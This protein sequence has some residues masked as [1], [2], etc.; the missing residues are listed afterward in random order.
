MTDD[1]TET[2]PIVQTTHGKVKGILLKSL[3]DEQFYAFDGIPYAVPPL[4]TLRF[5][6]PHDLKPWHGIRDC[7]K[8]SNKCLQVS[9][10]TKMVEGSEDCL[11]LNI[12]AK[13]LLGE[14]MPIMVYI[15]G[16]AFKGGDSS[17]RAWGPDYFMKE[18]VL[19]ISIGHRLGPLGFLSFEDPSLEIPGNAG[20]KDIILALQWIR[21]N[22]AKF[23]GD[24]DRITIFGHSSGSMAV[25]LLLASPQTEGL[26][27]K[28]ILMAGYSMEL[29]SLPHL[30]F[31]LAKHLGYEGE[32]ID[33]PV[34]EFLLKADPHLLVSADFF[35]PAEK[36][37][38]H[39][40]AFKPSIERYATPKAVL[41]AEP[42]DLQRTAWS[43]RIPII[44]G[45]N[46][47]EG[48]S[49]MNFLKLNPTWLRD[50]QQNPE[51]ALPWTLRNHCDPG[52]RRQ[53]GQ[54]LINH[55][56]QAHG[57][58]LTSNHTDAL[59]DL[60][61]HSMVHS[62]DRLIQSRLV[63]GQASTYLYRFDFDSPDFNFYRIRFMGKEQRGV[64]HVDELGYIFVIPATFKLDN[65]RPELTAICRMVAMF[66]EFAATSDPNALLTKPL[67]EWKPVTR[68]GKRMV[69][70]ISEELKFIP[71]PEMLKLKFFDRLFE[72]AGVPFCF[73][74]DFA[75]LR[76]TH[77]TDNTRCNRTMSEGQETCELTLPLGQI[78]GVKRRS[79][80]DDT[81]FSFEKIPFAKPPVGELRFKAPVPAD[82]WS[83]VLDCTHFAEKPTQRNLM[84]RD[85]EGIEDC[86]YLNVYSKQLKSDKPLPVMVYIYGGAF[87]IGEATRELYGPDYFMAKDVVLVTL[88][89]RVDCL[90]FLSLKDPSLK[91]PGNAGLKD[92][93][94]ALKW[95]KQNI[96]NFNGDDKNITVFG[97][98]AGGCSTHFM[99]CSEQARGLFHKA[100]PMSGTVHNYWSDSPREDFAFRL[101]QQ[102]G[103]TGE[104]NDA[105]VLEHLRGLPAR[106]L[107]NHNLIN[108]GHHRN[109]V[110][111]AFGPTVEA[112]VGDD[113]VVPKPPVEMA[114]DAWSNNLPT[115]LGGTS[116]EGLFMY[117]AVSAN[118]KALDT[119]NQDPTRLVPRD[120]RDVSNEEE[121]L[122]YGRRLLKAYFGDSLPSSERFMNI[123]DFYSYKVFWHG[124]NRALNARLAYA[125][126]PTYYY[127][128]DFDSPNFNFFRA[129]F[130]GDNIKTGVAHAD[131][132]SYLFR[133]AGSWKLEKSSA[134]Y[135][136]IERMIGIW[137]AFAATSNPNCPEIGHLEW[138][139][140]TKDNPKSVLNISNDVKIIDLPEYEK[141]QIWDGIYKP[142]QLI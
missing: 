104:N 18:R 140:S 47:G 134:E 115:M 31:R 90:G 62:M 5:K 133:N 100:I 60:F 114:R 122:E 70:N 84:T 111:F 49:T 68:F 124:F 128:F 11:Y 40:I 64:S 39:V 98:S 6:E 79:L 130:C 34:L 32:N 69:L 3:Y 22:A 16:G 66:V 46:S 27:H 73:G 129:K 55:F 74:F 59:T 71:Q 137:T 142:D 13:T 52:Q 50:L 94:L 138:N 58:K 80:Y 96:S 141:L 12:S 19:Y 105:K 48:L 110:L 119:L 86:L 44:L 87:T 45:A 85:I 24:P 41:Q 127:R 89:Y 99:M 14:P 95:V 56:C 92:Q 78:K 131:D 20:L 136:T 63:H 135:R 29:N 116:F 2:S 112:Y 126:A 7:S 117:P 75:K 101:A 36:G 54:A 17:R 57:H 4:G 25:Q 125:K 106:D 102:H 8:P 43:N 23:N 72:M 123:L 10:Y 82:A 77:L 83:G 97:E 132:L 35:T 91:V 61:T 88:N 108:P 121:N 21:A 103:F 65:S 28:A 42:V 1:Y 51:R 120:V 139:P 113:C 76:S 33:G 81:Y 109:G 38:G 30:E 67:V 15:H 118:L 37:Q 93:V 53:L 107:V 9:S 26:F